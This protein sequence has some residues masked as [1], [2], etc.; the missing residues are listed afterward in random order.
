MATLTLP[1]AAPPTNRWRARFAHALDHAN[2]GRVKLDI[3]EATIK[4]DPEAKI[5]LEPD[6]LVHLDPAAKVSINSDTPHPSEQQLQA[7]GKIITNFTIFKTVTIDASSSV[8]TG[9]DFNSSEQTTPYFQ[10]CHYRHQNA[11]GTSSV[12]TIAKNGQWVG[13]KASVDAATLAKQCVWFNG[14]ATR[15]GA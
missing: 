12:T 14:T 13:A 15:I 4:L 5:R 1:I 11:D 10:Y 2:L 9:W 7:G 6:A 3:P 8:Q